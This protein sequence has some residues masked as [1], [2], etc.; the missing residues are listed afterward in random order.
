MHRQKMIWFLLSVSASCTTCYNA[1]NH[2]LPS[3]CFCSFS[4]SSW[5]CF[6]R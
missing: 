2:S 4:F 3:R 5:N 6:S 1:P